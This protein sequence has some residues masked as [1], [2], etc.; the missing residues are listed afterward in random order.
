MSSPIDPFGARSS[1]QTSGGSFDYYKLQSLEDAGIV[2]LSKLPISIRIVLENALR[3][4]DQSVASEDDV[5]AVASWSP[6]A[7]P[8]REVPYMP[9]RVLLQDF[10]GVP[11]VVDLAAMRSAMADRG[12]DP[13]KID[14]VVRSDMVIDHSVQVDYFASEGA[15]AMNI[16]REFERN[17]ERYQLLKWAQ[18]AFNNLNV[19]PPGVG[20]VHQV[21]LEYLA[22][23]VMTGES[24]GKAIAYPDTCIGTDSHTTMVNG[25]GVLGWGV[26]GIEA[27][28]V[29][30]AQ[31]YYMLVPEVVG[32]KLTGELPEG[33]TA[34]DL[35][36][37]ITQLL[38]ATG[39][40]EKFVE[41][42]GPGLETLP[43]ADRA[44]ISNM[45]PEYGA[46]CGL[47]P[48]DDQ[49]LRYLRTSGRSE[50]Q[51]DLVE[52]YYKEQGMF[53]TADTPDAEYTKRLEFDLSGVEP[54]MAGPKRPQDRL[55]LSQVS[56]NFKEVFA[57]SPSGGART[58]IN[59]DQTDAE[60][61][62]ASVVIAAITS[63]TNTSNPSV[64]MGAGL[65]A[66]NAVRKGLNRKSWV[67]TSMAP[68]SQVVTGY[69]ENSGVITDLEKLGFGVVGYGC[70]TCIGNSGPLPAPVA[71][72]VD[73]HELVAAA[74]IS[75]NRNFEGRVHPQVQANYLAS[76][77]L[78]VAYALAGTV[79]IDL[80]T[81]P[82]GTGS[83]GEDVYLKDIWP[84]QNEIAEEIAGSV[85]A[86]L[87]KE[88][89][90]AVYEGGEKWDSIPTSTGTLFDWDPGSTYIQKVS[91]FDGMPDDPEP[92]SDING[93]RVLVSFA[94]S[95]TTDHISPAGSI[96]PTA[97]SGQFLMAGDVPRR[98]FNSYGSRRG[99]HEVM[100]RGTFGNIRLRNNL[101]PERTGDWTAH[102][103]DGEEMRIFDASEK[104]RD[105]GV[106]LIVL[107]GKEYGTG[108]SR[109]WAAKGPKLLGVRAVIAES[110]ERIHR[111][112]LVGMGVLPLQ[113]VD[114][115]SAGSLGLTG[116][117][118]YDFGGIAS[119]LEPGQRVSVTA[120]RDNGNIV[121]FEALVRI[122][123]PVEIDYYRHGGVLN[124]V[125]RR[126]IAEG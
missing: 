72:A 34:T 23:V 118:T 44:T 50:D 63:C 81:Q 4:S 108:S 1:I 104:Y 115:Q 90:G 101:V 96:P 17:Q 62:D 57:N 119:G 51:V 70:T 60:I 78:V 52:R 33:A 126:F 39:V 12:A 86:E 114:G 59:I 42:F 75:G 73:D 21:N 67:K 3:H 53:R 125:L 55:T 14:P 98:D 37:T 36:L 32:V 121:E 123:T 84:S 18:G 43:L 48:V 79:D 76:P 15:L 13:S 45:A 107:A 26:G 99:N 65:L 95:V 19:I 27:E 47:F 110:Y 40:V 71:E 97:P 87:F 83:D 106:P 31:P 16:D 10:T 103:P 100:V 41:F 38:R 112:N 29:M 2:N 74:V 66:R 109:D 7:T 102:L 35:V 111:S 11:A 94:D 80:S 91:F 56:S 124:Y 85:S 54:S 122:D 9:A 25:L 120:A 61:G 117:E 105:E 69:L 28:A 46:T 92:L 77:M 89:Y 8:S 6:T 49:T 30:L 5:R 88:K 116:T 113:Y 82:V 64:M 24:S 58:S 93:A 22:P 20:I 68:G